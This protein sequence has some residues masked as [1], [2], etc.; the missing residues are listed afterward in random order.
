M[1]EKVNF[2]VVGVFVLVLGAALI[3][4][5]LWLSSGN[6]YRK[7]YDLYRTYM[8]ESVSGLSLDA[9]V[10]YHGVE[11][12]RVREIALAPENVEQVRLTLAI[13]RGT[14]VKEDT[15]AVVQ[16]QGLTGIAFVELTGGGRDSP[17]LRAQPGEEYPVIKAGP[18]LMTRLDSALTA[19]LTN[20]NRTSEN[21]NALLDEDNRRA[22]K[23]ALADIEVLSRTL[24]ARSAAIDSSLT[25]AARAME[26]TARLSGELAQL[27]QRVQRSADAFDRMANELARAGAGASGV[28]NDARGGVQQFTG[29]TLPEVHQLVTELRDLT[30]S[31]RRFSDQLEENPSALLYG[32]PAGK[33]G[34]GE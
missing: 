16:T 24:A 15:V 9:P 21:I 14:P 17:P 32:K 4:S 18:S 20:L 8:Q 30:G 23:H 29:E 11:V 2:A 34:P 7:D 13:E 1:E 28:L 19:L 12:G 33:R 26:N 6:S 31:L 27:A 5:V 3:G 25:N 10:R 22:I